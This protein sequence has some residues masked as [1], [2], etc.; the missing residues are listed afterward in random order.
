[1]IPML[2]IG[3][4]LEALH[5]LNVFSHLHF[6]CLFDFAVSFRFYS[7]VETAFAKCGMF[8]SFCCFHKD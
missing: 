5:L 6:I 7:A 8:R 3:A 2:N 4:S 1:M